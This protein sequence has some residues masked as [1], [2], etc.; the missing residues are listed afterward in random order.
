MPAGPDPVAVFRALGGG[1]GSVLLE[2]P[3]APVRAIVGLDPTTIAV[4]SGSVVHWTH[5]PL[6]PDLADAPLPELLSVV[7][8]TPALCVLGNDAFRPAVHPATAHSVL[9]FPSAL[10]CFE[11]DRIRLTAAS[12]ARLD[13][14]TDLVTTAAPLPPLT[15]PAPAPV[16]TFDSEIPDP[17]YRELLAAAHRRVAAGE[18][19][20]VTISRRFAAPAVADPVTVYRAL[21][22]SNPSPYHFLLRLPGVTLVGASPQGLISVQGRRASVPVI[23]GTRRRGADPAED[24][25]NAAELLADPKER[26]E[27][28][29]LVEL[30][31]ADL[32]AVAEPDSIRVNDGAP[33]VRRYARVMHLVSEVAGTLAAGRTAIEALAAVLPAGT[34]AGT[35][36]AAALR[37]IDELE[38]RPRGL[39]GGGVGWLDGNGDL[40][41]CLGIRTLQFRADLAYCQ[42]GAGVVA[43]SDPDLEVRESRD[44]ASALFASLEAAGRLGE[45]GER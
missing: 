23:A 37:L 22:A 41:C 34:V 30:A 16:T 3:E 4:A 31:R 29:M 12:P 38:P 15:F 1:E 39:Y 43:D 9:V 2:R 5:G 40:D 45:L 21:R 19:R 35:P 13:E 44:K 25:A 42:A 6:R 18:A 20:Q 10:I 28:A 36:R 11:D 14:L 32:A 17:A 27:H 33:Q 7:A 8:G 24:D 26:D